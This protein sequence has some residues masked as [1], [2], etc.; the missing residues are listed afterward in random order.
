RNHPRERHCTG[1]TGLQPVRAAL[2]AEQSTCGRNPDLPASGFQRHR[3]FQRSARR[4]GTAQE[5]LP[6]RHGLQ[7]RL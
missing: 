7:H 2:L 6:G 3:H 5:E 1:R 4:D